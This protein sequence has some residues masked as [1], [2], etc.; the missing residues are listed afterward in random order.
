M[1]WLGLAWFEP[2]A[3]PGLDSFCLAWLGLFLFVAL[4]WFGMAW[5]G[6]D[7]EETWHL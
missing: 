6:G 4:A 7:G 2:A 5:L 3:R 1:A